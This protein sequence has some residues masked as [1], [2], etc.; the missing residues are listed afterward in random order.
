MCDHLGIHLRME[1]RR[2]LC[3]SKPTA[4][5][6]DEDSQEEARKAKPTAL[7]RDDESSNSGY[8]G[9]SPALGIARGL[10]QSRG[11]GFKMALRTKGSL[12]RV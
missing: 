6:R 5:H 11:K 4:L 8:S 2:R 9:N 7:H 10:P 1:C 3:N 12:V